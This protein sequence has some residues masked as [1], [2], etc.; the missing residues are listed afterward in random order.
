MMTSIP[1]RELG[2]PTPFAYSSLFQDYL[3]HSPDI[4]EFFPRHFANNKDWKGTL[5]S[6]AGRG[7]DRSELVKILSQQNRSYQCGVKTLANIDL[8]LN[9]NTL[10]VVTGQQVGLFS[11]PLYTLYKAL[12][13]VALTE[14]LAKAFPDYSFVPVFWVEGED[15][16][17]D[18]VSK[19]GLLTASNDYS[20]F[21]YVPDERLEGKN[22]GASGRVAF[23]ETIGPFLD[24][25]RASLPPTD[26]SEQTFELL[27]TAH[28]PGMTFAQSF[29]HMMN[30]LMEESGLIFLDPN[31]PDVKVLLRPVFRKE[32]EEES[33]ACRRVI[34]RSELLEERYHAQVKPRSVNIFLHHEKG[35]FAIEPHPK[36]F[37]LKGVRQHYTKDELLT[38]LEDHPESFSPN[39]VLRPLCQ[40]TLL[41]TVAYVGGPAEVAYMAQL[42]PLYEQFGIPAP[43]IYPRA[44]ATIVEDK[45][46]KVFQRFAVSPLELFK[47]AEGVK[48]RIA[49]SVSDFQT[50]ELFAATVTSIEESLNSLRSGILSI[51]KTLEG[52]LDNT[53]GRVTSAVDVLKQKTLAAQKRQHETF[54]RQIDKALLHIAPDNSPQERTVSIVYFLNKYGPEFVRWLGGELRTDLHAHQIIKL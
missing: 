18:E 11:G 42:Q 15:H 49:A 33:E 43:I 41:P 24:S 22:L 3:A 48:A 17:F 35:R 5:E 30:V 19:V 31:S 28:Q 21:R 10:A 20:T 46:E 54:L 9:D 4:Q 50:D 29:I 53:L 7:L 23:T 40:D 27:R 51:D 1:Y 2:P 37:A 25:I 8:L 45:V 47:D 52:P 44:S 13:A 26:F 32:I 36:G 6:V 16:D 14:Q 38:L 39:V 12:T 34:E